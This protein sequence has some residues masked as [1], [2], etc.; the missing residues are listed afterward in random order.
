MINIAHDPILQGYGGVTC[1]QERWMESVEVLPI[2]K[3][4]HREEIKIL[5][6]I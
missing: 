6:K 3:I 1:T 2:L 4:L 5:V